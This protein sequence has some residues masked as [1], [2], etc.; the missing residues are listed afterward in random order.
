MLMQLSL[1]GSSLIL[2]TSAQEQPRR[3]FDMMHHP[4]WTSS[5]TKALPG[6]AIHRRKQERFY[7]VGVRHES[8]V[9]IQGVTNR[10][11]VASSCAAYAWFKTVIGHIQSRLM[12]AFRAALLRWPMSHRRQSA[13]KSLHRCDS[14]SSFTAPRRVL[15]WSHC[16]V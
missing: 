10:S 14:Q 4:S 2:T 6:L 11:F 1:I 8:A 7:P 5:G 9:S 16:L 13:V 12:N 3:P 15:S